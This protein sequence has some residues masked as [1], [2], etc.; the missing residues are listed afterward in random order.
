M[1]EKVDNKTLICCLI[2]THLLIRLWYLNHF[3][4]HYFKQLLDEVFV[5]SRKIKVQVS[6]ISLSLWLRLITLTTTLII[7]DITKTK[8]HNC[9][10]IHYLQENNDKRAL[11]HW[12]Q[13]IFDKPCSYVNLTLLLEIMHYRLFTNL[14]AD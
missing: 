3:K 9:F 5:I 2:C 11:S 6:V 12:T 7:S 4:Q 14:L 1:Y 8:S 10:I 13:S